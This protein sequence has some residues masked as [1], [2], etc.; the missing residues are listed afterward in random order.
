MTVIGTNISALRSANA[1]SSASMSLSQ[2]MERLS[3]GKRIN[4]AKDDA[5]GLAI[6]SRMT[7]QVKSMAVAIRNAG[8][9]IS[10]TQ[11]AEGALGEVTNMLQRMK[12]LATQSANGT[13]GTSER[14]ALQ[15]ETSQLLSQINDISRTTNFNGLNLLDGSV[16]GLTLQTG[17]NSGDT[18]AIN[19]NRVSTQS[20]GLDGAQAVSGR[21]GGSTAIS[22][23]LQLNGKQVFSAGTT[24]STAKD[25]ATAVNNNPAL[26]VVATASNSLSTSAAVT[27][28]I[29]N[30]TIN[31]K[32]IAGATDAATLVETINN[33]KATYGVTAKL[34]SDGKITLSNDDGSNI[35]TAGG[36]FGTN[37]DIK[38][39]VALT[40]ADGSALKIA[41]TTATDLSQ[42]GL[43]GSDGASFTG[44]AVSAT[45]NTALTAGTLKING[46]EIGAAT[47]GT[48]AAGNGTSYA[49]AINLKTAETGVTATSTAG[50]ITLTTTTGGPVRVEGAGAATIG[51]NSQGGTGSEGAA[52]DIS[53][54][55]GASRAL[56]VIDKALDGVSAKRGDLGAIQNRLEVT[57][58]NLTTTTSNLS[59]ARS[60]I[61]DA[62]FSAESTALAKAQILSQAS[63]A[64]LAQAN[65]SQQGVL[66][67][68]S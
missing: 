48:A 65:Q 35:S 21:A 63:T 49:A 43:N 44:V 8:D 67:L 6:S 15:A 31:G 54:A 42:L 26:G 14:K 51:F 45:D 60:R 17:S 56:S 46:V 1:S 33:N 29:A 20:L 28:V 58:N 13:L 57:V 24:I 52:L 38:G 34:E 19:L 9:G 68:L 23:N 2:A 62:D 30:G 41:S 66:K 18:V 64:M 36:A 16:K 10:M 32:A 22:T 50:V 5:A 7:S 37:T 4:S 25:F 3:T 27:G 55:A 61:E 53:T 59:E 40:N 47:G 11:T 39:Y 12:E